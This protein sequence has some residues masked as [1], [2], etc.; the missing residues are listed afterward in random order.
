MECIWDREFDE[1]G[2]WYTRVPVTFE[3]G[4]TVV[5]EVARSESMAHLLPAEKI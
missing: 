5:E 1:K 4:E 2:P 3:D